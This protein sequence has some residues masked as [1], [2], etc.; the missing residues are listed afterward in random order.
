MSNY[1]VDSIRLD[2]DFN[3]QMEFESFLEQMHKTGWRVN[4]L[5]SKY[6]LGNLTT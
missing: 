1:R 2:G 3:N 6:Y 4:Q 5:Y